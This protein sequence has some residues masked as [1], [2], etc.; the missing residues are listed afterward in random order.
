M[1]IALSF[2]AYRSEWLRDI[3]DGSPSTTELGRRFAHKLLSDWLELDEAS[4][5]ILYCD[6]AGDGGIDVAYLEQ[7]ERT[8]PTTDGA[9]DGDAWYL[10]Q[11]K[12]GSAFRGV[13]TILEEGRKV[14]DTLTGHRP[15]LSSL[16]EQLVE[17]LANFRSQAST[18][19]QIVLVFATESALNDEEK[20]AL[21]DVRI[22]GRSRLGDLFDVAAVS[23]YTIYQRVLEENPEPLIVPM[24]A[25]MVESSPDLLVGTVSLTN[26][27]AFLK[28]YKSE[29]GDL[30]QIYDKNVRRFLGGRRRVNR[31]ITDTLKQHPDKFGLFNNGITIVV[32]DFERI[33]GDGLRLMNPYI[34]NGCQ[35]TRTIWEVFQTRLDA[36]GTGQHQELQ[37]WRQSA[38]QGVVVTKIVRVGEDGEALLGDITRYTNSQN[39]INDKDFLALRDDFRRWKQVME[40]RCGIFLEIQRG[41]WDSYRAQQRLRPLANPLTQ[42]ANAFDL[43]KVYGSGWLGDAGTAFGRNAAFLPNGTVYKRI[44]EPREGQRVFDVDDL[45]AAFLLQKSADSYGFGRGAPKV[46]RRQTR[47]LFYLVAVEILR[48]VVRRHN[49]REPQLPELTDAFLHLF[50]SGDSA[51]Q[52]LLDTAIEV[53]DEYM[54]QGSDDSVFTEPALFDRFNQDINGFLKW[55][56]LGKADS[57]P[58]LR[59]LINAYQRTMGRATGGLPAPREMITQAIF[60]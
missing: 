41:G 44:M 27:Y 57:T 37:T 20:R 43:L 23:I 4:A 48:D 31:G 24:K 12:Y 22:L 30:D 54:T 47:Y 52:Q 58:R 49:T 19:D 14:I 36:G 17:R 33:D 15:R 53:V 55:E 11:S 56:Q 50:V 18:N 5:D 28:T 9:M 45:Y 42:H 32:A 13:N 38:D 40:Q 60:D 16:G 1:S 6:G 2:E 3:E 25:A 59:S 8:D 7:G 34:V 51:R 39:A 10:V 29:T 35:T 21:E 46:T 26:L